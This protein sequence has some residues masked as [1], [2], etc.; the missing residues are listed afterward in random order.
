LTVGIDYWVE[1]LGKFNVRSADRHRDD[2][3]HV[4]G[5]AQ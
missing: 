2:A 5:V 3:A 4:K 1:R